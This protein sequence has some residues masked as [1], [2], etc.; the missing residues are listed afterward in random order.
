[1]SQQLRTPLS[2]HFY[3]A[4]PVLRRTLRAGATSVR[5]ASGA[6]AGLRS[7]V[8]QNL[9][10]GP[11]LKVAI[12]I[13]HATGGHGDGYL[14][15]G[16]SVHP[17]PPYPGSPDTRVDG[18]DE[19][20]RRARELI[21][22]G[23]DVLK[24]A[25]TGGGFGKSRPAADSLTMRPDELQEIVAEGNAAKVPVMAHAHSAEGA[26]MAAKA[27]VSSVEHGTFID[28]E[29]AKHLAAAGTFL[30]PTLLAS[31]TLRHWDRLRYGPL[32]DRHLEAVG[33]AVDA[34]VRIAAG[35][36]GGLAPHGGILREIDLLRSA[37]LDLVSALMAA[38]GNGAD[39]LR[40]TGQRGHITVGGAA[41]LL[42]VRGELAEG[43]LEPRLLQVWKAGK[44][45]SPMSPEYDIAAEN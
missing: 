17:F 25:V 37:G 10:E 18:P 19:A 4:I 34:G 43:P 20:R 28:Q 26:V 45:Y 6:D 30:V 36:D 14:A 3:R 16:Q 32:F 21:R 23:A 31:A 15:S 42:V 13:L 11:G 24:V 35:T 44:C 1:V 29:A 38:T 22:A 8:A 40:L 5:D 9:I 33:L 39:L 27:G 2:L 41:D 7:A 12:R